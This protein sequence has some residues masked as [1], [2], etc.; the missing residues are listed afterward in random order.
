MRQYAAHEGYEVLEEVVD[1]GQSG[2]SLER[3][4]MDR[5][6]DLVAAGG[7]SVVLAQ[8]R[9]RFAREPAYHY[10]LRREFEEYGTKLKALNDRG[11]GSPEGELTD[12]ILDQL[13]KYE[14]TKIAERTRRGKLHRAREGKIVPTHTADYGFEFN[15][16]RDNYVVNEPQ[17]AVVRRIFHMLGVE[18]MTMHA[19][20]KTFEREGIPAPGGGKRWDRTFFRTCAL[21]DVYCP[22]TYEE[23]K[24]LVSPDVAL[25]L[26]PDK[27]YGIWW[28]NRRRRKRTR[29][30]DNSPSGKSYR[31]QSA[32]TIR[33]REEWIAVP[34]PDPGIP[35]EW[36][37]AARDAIKDNARPSSTGRRF[38]ELSGGVAFCEACGRRLA[39]TAVRG[40]GG[41]SDKLHF[42]Y[43][44]HT[45]VAEGRDAC[46]QGKTFRAEELEGQVWEEVC[47]MLKNPEH[48]RADLEAMIEQERNGLRGDPEREVEAWLDKLSEVD[49]KRSRFQE[50]AAEGLITF[51]ELGAKLDELEETRTTARRALESLGR[52]QQHLA[53]L[54]RDKDAVLEYYERVAPDALEGLTPQERNHFY[55]ALRL[56]VA[57]KPGGGMEICGPF[58]DAP[59]VSKIGV[60]S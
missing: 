26:D 31:W 58:P 43:R 11:D 53:D 57:I 22:H 33:P 27:R 5:V 23:V 18:G 4:G 45:R 36:V 54:E 38:W 32:T 20:K 7:I 25:R 24:A 17:M 14:R 46:P 21:D 37:D 41:R 55:K 9:D 48:L 16:N 28:F 44:C 19:V 42:Y 40:N 3:P 2:A 50:M 35:R 1:P 51:E 12:G 29:V 13:A 59:V 52:R 10:L 34:V 56:R 15:T 60:S 39:T 8:D 47:G 6:R 49:S 30:S